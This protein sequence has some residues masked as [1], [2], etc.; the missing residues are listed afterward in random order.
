[1]K[2]ELAKEIAKTQSLTEIEE[3]L[4]KLEP[5]RLKIEEHIKRAKIKYFIPNE[6]QEEFI[7]GKSFI[8]LFMAGN[9]TGKTTIGVIEDI[10]YCLGYRP[11]LKKEDPDFRTKYEPPVKVRIY[12]EDFTEHINGVIVP[13]LREW[14]PHNEFAYRDGNPKK[15]PQGVPVLWKFKNGSS[16][17]LLTYEQ[18]ASKSEGWDGQVIHFDEPPPRATY[19]AAKRGLVVND[20]ICF[21]TLTPLKE[22]WLYDQLWMRSEKEEEVQ[23][24]EADITDNLRHER[25]WYGKPAMCGA[26]TRE[27][28]GRFTKDLTDDE[29]EARL[30][31]RFMHLS[32]LVYK[33]FN[34]GIHKI[35]WF[36]PKGYTI[37]EAIDPAT[38]KEIAVSFLA[39]APDGTKYAF[40]EIFLKG[41]I[42][43]VSAAI[44]QKR[45]DYGYQRPVFT[46]IDPIAVAKDPISGS[47]VKEEFKKA[48]DNQI[49]PIEG[50]KDRDRGIQLMKQV[51]KVEDGRA[52]IYVTDNCRR[53][54]YEFGH[55]IW[56]DNA[57]KRTGIQK[58]IPR[59][60]NDDMLE[61]LHRILITGAR[62]IEPK[63]KKK[64]RKRIIGLGC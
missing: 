40:D 23:G 61:N 62:Y 41:L 36:N 12:G 2:E 42:K 60:T 53:T 58:E 17:E 55:Y 26:L 4:K 52:G 56:D 50:S 27:A 31:G 29:K 39:V 35:R 32:G 10:S 49:L 13:A 16:I 5:I 38:R 22:P 64:T 51:L 57:M 8:K 19:I 18:D 6:K 44:L 7:R 45:K 1:M 30:H 21:F 9:K 59:K 24:I 54:L 63:D 20:G 11:Y 28:I 15:S 43:D 47:T 34:P 48:S 37:Y 3:K 25:E 46:I 14:I 33:E